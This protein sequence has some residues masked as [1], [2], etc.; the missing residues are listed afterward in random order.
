MRVIVIK[1]QIC[2]PTSGPWNTFQECAEFVLG[3]PTSLS[4]LHE[5]TLYLLRA[6]R[7]LCFLIGIPSE[8]SRKEEKGSRPVEKR[9]IPE[10]RTLLILFVTFLP[11]TILSVR[12][13]QGKGFQDCLR[14]FLRRTEK[15]AG[16]MVPQTFPVFFSSRNFWG[17]LRETFFPFLQSGERFWVWDRDGY[18]KRRKL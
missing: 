7:R 18:F 11:H 12:H 15:Y 3:I 9:K 13:F 1:F 8:A 17:K 6:S 4:F 16:T 5:L 10:F 14:S 2:N